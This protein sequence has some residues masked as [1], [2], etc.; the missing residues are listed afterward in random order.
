MRVLHVSDTH[1]RIPDRYPEPYDAFVHS[2]DMLPNLPQWPMRVLDQQQYQRNWVTRNAGALRG[3]IGDKPFLF[4]MANHDYWDPCEQMRD[5][6]IDARSLTHS[7]VECGGLKFTGFPWI[8]PVGGWN[9]EL[10]APEMAERVDRLVGMTNCGE[11]D[12]WVCHSPPHGILDVAFG[13]H[14]GIVPMTNALVYALYRKPLAYLCGH[15]HESHGTAE[16]DGI[17]F[18]NAATT[19]RIVEL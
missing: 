8:N 18:S 14:L 15:I 9:W 17:K 2:G 6:G 4:C 19:Q 1:G 7:V 10:E 12:V 16:Y 13:Q 11:V 3:W 5:M